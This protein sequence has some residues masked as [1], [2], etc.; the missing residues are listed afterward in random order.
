MITDIF[1]KDIIKILTL[2]SVSPGSKFVR[3]EIKEKTM[4]NNAPLDNALNILLNNGVL[5]KEKR[6]LSLNFENK[7]LKI[8]LDIIKKEHLRFKEIPL[9]IYYAVLDMSPVLAN[10][11][12]IAKAYLFGS[13]AKLIYTEKSDIDLAIILGKE[14]KNII[15]KVKNG[16]DKIEKKYN[17]NIELHFFEKKEMKQRDPII[18]E[19]LKNGIELY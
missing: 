13:Y 14:D 19:I 15:D 11:R 8:L 18:K 2:F 17:K 6:F 3:N 1:D 5:V 7:N 16:I 4:L 9:V 10:I 12:D